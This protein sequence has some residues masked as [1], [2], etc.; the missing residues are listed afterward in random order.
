MKIQWTIS[1]FSYSLIIYFTIFGTSS[2]AHLV[3]NPSAMQET[4][5]QSLG[6]E[7]LVEKGM[8]THS[9]IPAW[10]IPWNSSLRINISI[11]TAHTAWAKKTKL[12]CQ[13]HLQCTHKTQYTPLRILSTHTIRFFLHIFSA[14][15]LY[16]VKRTHF[17]SISVSCY[18]CLSIIHINCRKHVCLLSTSFRDERRD[19][20]C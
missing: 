13:C 20:V 4:W 17:W 10:K 1:K 16:L 9:S 6:W 18:L 15:H 11:K 3:K 12:K 7:D 2:V 19:F 8:A 14:C 5:V